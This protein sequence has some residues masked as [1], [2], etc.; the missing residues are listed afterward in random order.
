M[1]KKFSRR[2]R[3]Y[4]FK[5]GFKAGEVEIKRTSLVIDIAATPQ[6]IRAFFKKK[7]KAELTPSLN[8]DQLRSLYVGAL[9]LRHHSVVI[10]Q[11]Q[12]K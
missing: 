3:D 7:L 5:A 8:L 11:K 10:V 1:L 12:K 6:K 4:C 9:S 2:R